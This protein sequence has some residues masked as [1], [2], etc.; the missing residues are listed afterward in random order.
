MVPL[1]ALPFQ[2]VVESANK[3]C[4]N[5]HHGHVKD[6]G[7]DIIM[8]TVPSLRV[9]QDQSNV[10]DSVYPAWWHAVRL[11]TLAIEPR[12]EYLPQT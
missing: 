7:K 4:S 5:K 11:L 9:V 8:C 3:Y 6:R 12:A 10:Q 2:Q 1:S